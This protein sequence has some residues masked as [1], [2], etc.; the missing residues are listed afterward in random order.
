[1]NETNSN[2]TLDVTTRG[3]SELVMTRS[4][5][6][7]RALV[8]DAFTKPELVQRWLLGPDGWTMPVCEI[9]LRPGGAFRYRWRSDDGAR[10]FG[11]SGTFR[12][13]TAPIRI[14]HVE[15]MDGM[16]GEAVVTTNF[17]E[18]G[19][20]TLVVMAIDYGTRKIRDMAHESGMASG[21]AASFDRLAGMLA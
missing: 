17:S 9:D 7:P 2:R 18:D 5:A 21:V 1:M 6:A 15:R 3:E 11:T 12:E 8:F 4:L 10:E 19:G 20:E 16:P 13:V 14:V